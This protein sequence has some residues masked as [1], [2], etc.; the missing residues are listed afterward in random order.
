MRDQLIKLIGRLASSEAADGQ[1]GTASRTGEAG[2]GWRGVVDAIGDAAVVLDAGARVVHA[3]PAFAEQY[4]NLAVGQPLSRFLRHPELMAAADACEP[5]TAPAIVVLL[6]RLPVERKFE[7]RVVPLTAASQVRDDD[8]ADDS[9]DISGPAI[10][11]TLRDLTEQDRLAQMRED[12]I[13]NASHEL[14]TPLAS[15]KGFI[16]T[17]QGPARHDAVARERFLGLMAAQAERMTRLIDDLL[18]LSRAEMRAH[19][20]PR[21][22]VDLNELSVHV[23][24][25]L[26]PVAQAGRAELSVGTGDGPARVRGDRDEL[27]QVLTNLVQNAITYGGEGVSVTVTVQ[28]RSGVGGD[29][30]AVSVADTGPG[31]APNDLPRLTERFFRANVSASRSKGGTGLGLAIVKHIVARHRGELEITSKL[32]Q[33]A[34]FTVEFPPLG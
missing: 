6:E 10:L 21:G 2:I 32:G 27:V 25:T 9:P 5:G 20:T 22:I 14:R 1:T 26:Q 15:V 29:R 12:F 19:V 33:G 34:T 24:Q 7:A 11:I 17:L 28:R 16:E 8:V 30:V 18:S 13:A 31:I 23:A 4:P 3:N